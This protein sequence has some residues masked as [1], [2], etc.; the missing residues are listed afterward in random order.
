MARDATYNVGGISWADIESLTP[1]CQ[2]DTK[3]CCLLQDESSEWSHCEQQLPPLNR[4]LCLECFG[5]FCIAG[6]NWNRETGESYSGRH[7]RGH[8]AA[9]CAESGHA[10]VCGLENLSFFCHQCEMNNSG[11]DCHYLAPIYAQLH[12]AKTGN[13]PLGETQN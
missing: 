11:D 10:I 12:K 2:E 4:A 13:Y 3:T 9:H 7:I 1:L 5:V 8:M 6:S